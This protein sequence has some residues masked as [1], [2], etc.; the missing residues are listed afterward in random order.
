[1]LILSLT[2]QGFARKKALTSYVTQ[3]HYFRTRIINRF[4]SER[5]YHLGS[6]GDVILITVGAE[7][8][9]AL[10]VGQ[11]KY[12]QTFKPFY[13]SNNVIIFNDD[14]SPAG[15]R[16][17]A[18]IPSWFRDPKQIKRIEQQAARVNMDV[19]MSKVIAICPQFI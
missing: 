15:T 2:S 13:E 8:R 10:F 3:R 12:H 18:P 16:I 6:V 5:R 7:F 11:T 19:Q 4:F 1:M 9:R 14:G 17:N